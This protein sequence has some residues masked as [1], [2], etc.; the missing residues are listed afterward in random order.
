MPAEI[1]CFGDTMAEP[2]TGPLVQ[3]VVTDQAAQAVVE[4]HQARVGDSS[5]EGQFSPREESEKQYDP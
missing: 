4:S 1:W 3:L 2:G 5:L